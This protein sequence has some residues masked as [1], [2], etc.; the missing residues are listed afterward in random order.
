MTCR[1][2]TVS[3]TTVFI[4]PPFHY[5]ACI[6]LGTLLGKLFIAFASLVASTHSSK[7]IHADKLV[8]TSALP[9]TSVPANMEGLSN[10]IAI[11]NHEETKNLY[12]IISHCHRM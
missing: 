1:L 7:L 10:S 8:K 12:M 3:Y 9:G 6:E 2:E 4:T 11:M 5:E